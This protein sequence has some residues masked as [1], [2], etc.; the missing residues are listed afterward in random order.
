MFPTSAELVTFSNLGFNIS[1][2]F[3]DSTFRIFMKTMNNCTSWCIK[4]FSR[5][6]LSFVIFFQV[7]LDTFYLLVIFSKRCSLIRR[8]TFIGILF[9]SFSTFWSFCIIKWDVF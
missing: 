5:G 8:E 9:G 7:W 2:H 6:L 1:C 4:G 3:I